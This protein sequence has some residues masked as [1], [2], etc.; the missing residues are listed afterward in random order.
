MSYSDAC[1]FVMEEN[2]AVIKELPFFVQRVSAGGRRKANFNFLL[3]RIM[4]VREEADSFF[5]FLFSFVL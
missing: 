1:A 5:P 4:C 3:Q 2:T